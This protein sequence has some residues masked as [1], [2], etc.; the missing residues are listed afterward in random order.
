M[1]TTSNCAREAAKKYMFAL[2]AVVAALLIGCKESPYINPPGDN[3]KNYDS[4][5]VLKADTNGIVISIEEALTIGSKLSNGSS[6]SEQYKISGIVASI[7][8]NLDD[9]PVKY[10]NVNFDLSDNNKSIRCQ[11]TNCINNMPF[12]KKEDMPAVGTKIT[13][14]GPISNYNGSAQIKNGFIV[15]IDNW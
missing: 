6:T 12:R 7:S 1:K 9:I 11:Y 10:T 2:T 3:S 8:T 4:I 14:M 5:P 13:V 15:R